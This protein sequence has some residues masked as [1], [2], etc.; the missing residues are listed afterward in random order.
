MRLRI[1]HYSSKSYSR[2]ELG[3]FDTSIAVRDSVAI[4]PPGFS[5]LRRRH[6]DFLEFDARARLQRPDAN[7]DART[8]PEY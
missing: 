6:D 1:F 4:L 5:K 3:Y 2:A 8:E 7:M